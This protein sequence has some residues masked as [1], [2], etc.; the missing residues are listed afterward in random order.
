VE[1]IVE[2]AAMR[3]EE[4]TGFHPSEMGTKKGMISGI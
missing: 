3:R 2:R 1:F 4:R